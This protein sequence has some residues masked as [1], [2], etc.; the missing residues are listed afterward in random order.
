MVSKISTSIRYIFGGEVN[1]LK[2]KASIVSF[3][4]LVFLTS[5][6]FAQDMRISNACA[7]LTFS[8]STAN[9]FVEIPGKSTDKIHASIELRCGNQTIKT[10]NRYS[11]DG[12]LVLDD[13]VSVV[14]GNTYELVVEY[15]VNGKAQQSFSDSGTCN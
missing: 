6:A 10:W 11:V 13:T 1:Y 4:L 12:Y 9:C 3:F 15:T 8:G 14:R 2:V 7:D 5:N